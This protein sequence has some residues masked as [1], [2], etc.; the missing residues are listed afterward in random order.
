MPCNLLGFCNSIRSELAAFVDQAV[1]QLW[2][3]KK[4][5]VLLK[6]LNLTHKVTGDTLVGFAF[7]NVNH[8]VPLEEKDIW[9]P[10]TT[11]TAQK[12]D[13]LVSGDLHFVA[14]FAPVLLFYK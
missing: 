6:E 12:R 1:V 4:G 2:H 3:R 13:S 11:I 5:R 14:K 9:V 10:L 7:V 8:L